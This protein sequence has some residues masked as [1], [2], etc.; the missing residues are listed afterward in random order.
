[1]KKAR[2]F[3]KERKLKRLLKQLNKQLRNAKH[4]N[5][6][7]STQRLVA[8][9]KRLVA[10]L[11]PLLP[12]ARLK[13]ILGSFALSF[14]LLSA[15]NAHAQN[16]LEPVTNPFGLTAIDGGGYLFPAIA[17]LDDDGDLD[18][19]L[20][21]VETEDAYSN[22]F[23]YVENTGSSNDPQFGAQETTPFG[24]VPEIVDDVYSYWEMPT[25]VDIDNDGD[26]DLFTTVY[27]YNIGTSEGEYQVKYYENTGSATSP[28]FAAP[29]VDAFGFEP[30]TGDV[31][32]IK[33]SFADLDGDGDMDLLLGSSY[34][35]GAGSYE[36][37]MHYY[38]NTGNANSPAFASPVTNAFGIATVNNY[39]IPFFAD[40]DGDGDLDLWIT[41]D[42][43]DGFGIAYQENIGQN[44]MTEFGPAQENPFGLFTPDQDILW[45]PG[46]ADMDGDGD[47]DIIVSEY[48][49]DETTG[50]YFA[51]FLYFENNNFPIGIKE[52]NLAATIQLSPNPTTNILQINTKEVLS[53]VA[54]Y[55]IN[56]K[57]L[58]E[59]AGAIN[60]LEIGH[61]AKGIYLVQLTNIYGEVSTKKVEKL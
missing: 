39:A 24:L 41:T 44:G 48:N 17:D 26:L 16:F 13:T 40:M 31:V 22:G 49:S 53:K 56:G 55:D 9:I 42:G 36:A 19:L 15:G 14:G 12:T 6:G 52:A 28:Q 45:I 57:L 27:G 46:I 3:S 23:L 50:T 34:D 51:N 21:S 30:L 11:K 43:D 32:T 47:V 25:L 18:L 10:E 60:Q 59:K 58:I 54:L 20:F 29:M 33:A 37:D 38:E 5:L 61:L 7:N 1:M 4:H 2:H 8:K 35:Y